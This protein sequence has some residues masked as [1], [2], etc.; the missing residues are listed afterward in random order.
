MSQAGVISVEGS[1]GVIDFIQGNTGGPVPPNALDT[2]FIV[3]SGGVSVSGNSLLNTLTITASIPT[4]T[5]NVISTNQTL[6]A[7]NGYFCAGGSPISLLLPP[8][9]NTGD[10]ISVVLSGA[11]SFAITQGAGQLIQIGNLMTT[12]G[13]GG[14]LSSTQQGDTLVFVC[15]TP[16]LKWYVTSSMGNPLIV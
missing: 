8:V 4:F 14:S 1:P 3:G 15:M 9:S 7:S 13:V 2:I 10:T 5:W 6:V 12:A 11:A 16:N